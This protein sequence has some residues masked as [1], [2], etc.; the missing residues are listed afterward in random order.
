MPATILRLRY[1]QN[2]S[3]ISELRVSSILIKLSASQHIYI[4]MMAFTTAIIRNL[5]IIFTCMDQSVNAPDHG[6]EVYDS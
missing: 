3:T 1:L 2:L 4:V 6:R 5:R